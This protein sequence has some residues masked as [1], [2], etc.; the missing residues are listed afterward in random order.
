MVGRGDEGV[1]VEEADNADGAIYYFPRYSAKTHFSRAFGIC[2]WK[3]SAET[4]APMSL[5]GSNK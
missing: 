4:D 3:S 1:L 5:K 2:C